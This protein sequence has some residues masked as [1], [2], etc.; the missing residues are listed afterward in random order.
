MDKPR[1]FIASSRESLPLVNVLKRELAAVA[2]ITSWNDPSVFRAGFSFLEELVRLSKEFDLGLFLYEKDDQVISRGITSLAPRDNVIFEHG[3]FMSQLG[4][5]QAFA[6]APRGGVKVMSDLGGIKLLEYEESGKAA[7]LRRDLAAPAMSYSA[8]GTLSSVLE[9]ELT[10]ALNVTVLPQ[11]RATLADLKIER[12]AIRSGPP[13][14][15]GVAEPLLGLISAARKSGASPVVVQQ[16]GLDL[17]VAWAIV[18]DRIL[19]NAD[20]RN[21]QWRCLIIDPD[22]ASLKA[23][24]S[25][26]L[27]ATTARERIAQIQEYCP[28][29]AAQLAARQVTFECRSYDS[30]PVVH[31]FFV[32]NAGLLWS[33][34]DIQGGLLRAQR[35]Q[36]WEFDYV[37][38]NAHVIQSFS[39]WFQQLFTTGHPVWP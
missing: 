15:V 32:Q 12:V 26:T 10:A 33:M 39:H 28:G 2:D 24:S 29:Q 38:A 20:V 5:H 30:A 36:F 16:L 31:G 17:E 9:A 35:T 13:D 14:V 34:S 1:L 25:G 27:S 37:P 7:D 4:P 22:G 3:L 11:L 8:K 6:I 18:R 21:L 23:M 19:E